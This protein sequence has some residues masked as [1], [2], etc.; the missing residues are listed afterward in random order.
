M[1]EKVLVPNKRLKPHLTWETTQGTTLFKTVQK[2]SVSF[3]Y[4]SFGSFLYLNDGLIIWNGTTLTT[5]LTALYH[6]NQTKTK[7]TSPFTLQYTPQV[8]CTH[9][10]VRANANTQQRT[11]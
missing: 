10:D 5:P 3:I 8:T 2:V 7:V 11:C 4:N 9:K 1:F 6:C